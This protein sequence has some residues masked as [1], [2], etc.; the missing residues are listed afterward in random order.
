MRSD[1][2]KPVK[3]Q[4]ISGRLLIQ[5]MIVV[6]GSP[7]NYKKATDGDAGLF[8]HQLLKGRQEC[9]VYAVEKGY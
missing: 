8:P 1:D 9:S 2:G 6:T 4:G 7:F 3:N 5:N